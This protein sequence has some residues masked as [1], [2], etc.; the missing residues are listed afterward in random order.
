[1]IILFIVSTILAPSN[2]VGG[3]DTE[4]R[5]VL[6]VEC[7]CGIVSM[8]FGDL[9]NIPTGYQLCNGKNGTPDLQGRFPIG[10][11][12]EGEPS[13]PGDQGGNENCEVNITEAN[14]PSHTHNIT[15]VNTDDSQGGHSHDITGTTSED[16]KHDHTFNLS[17]DTSGSHNHGLSGGNC[18]Y[19]YAFVMD[20]SG[21]VGSTNYQISI[22]FV[23]DLIRNNIANTAQLM[24]LSFNHNQDWIYRFSQTQLPREKL[25]A[26]DPDL[27]IDELTIEKSDFNSGGTGTKHA[28]EAAITEFQTNNFTENNILILV[29]DGRPTG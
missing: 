12:A 14:L 10:I 3:L 27:I 19:N 23:I 24:A 22:D 7:P 8:W 18:N 13:T 21:S 25:Q 20:E 11:A 4:F 28:M 5:V 2:A 1:M 16:G 6:P 9:A 29:T 15:A 26:G 17:A